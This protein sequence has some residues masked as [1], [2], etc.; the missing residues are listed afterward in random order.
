MKSA[1]LAAAGLVA[2]TLCASAEE[3]KKLT[4]DECVNVYLGLAN[5]DAFDRI[6]KDGSG[7]KVVKA[8]YKLGD[9]RMTIAL[10][11][12]V[13]RPIVDAANKTRQ[14]LL[15]EMGPAP[16]DK[17]ATAAEK[18]AYAKATAEAV[19]SFEASMKEPCPVTPGRIKLSDLKIGDG[20][21][22]NA[23]PPSVLAAIMPIVD[24]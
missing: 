7:E 21:E 10:D 24:R 15:A 5:L 17:T 19:S 16:D 18:A 4:M 12:G 6:V 1:Y 3:P 13:L 2:A 23:I 22:Q 14:S 8:Q 9:A 20:P 11:Q